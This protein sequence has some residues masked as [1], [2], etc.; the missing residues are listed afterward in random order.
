[1]LDW[2]ETIIN[3][4]N[5]DKQQGDIAAGINVGLITVSSP[6]RYSVVVSRKEA[7]LIS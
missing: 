5:Y 1:M 4:N 3:I 7:G 2:P 6:G